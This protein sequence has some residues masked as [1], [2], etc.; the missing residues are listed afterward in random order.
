MN[1]KRK[2]RILVGAACFFGWRYSCWRDNFC[3]RR[4]CLRLRYEAIL[5]ST[6]DRVCSLDSEERISSARHVA[7]SRRVVPEGKD[8]P[9]FDRCKLIAWTNSGLR[10]AT[11][12]GLA[13][14]R[15]IIEQYD[16]RTWVIRTAD[17]GGFA[18]PLNDLALLQPWVSNHAQA[19]SK[20]E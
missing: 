1:L 16:G 17:G 10:Q 13:I 20:H 7:R 14:R 6:A 11:G 2:G 8:Q 3:V 5:N 18:L 9:D 15:G 4:S 19:H 12:F